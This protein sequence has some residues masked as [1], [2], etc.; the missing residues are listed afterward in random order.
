M[1]AL[2]VLIWINKL[3]LDF[4]KYYVF[5]MKTTYDGMYTTVTLYQDNPAQKI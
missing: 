1:L 2:V 4:I 5:S 3:L